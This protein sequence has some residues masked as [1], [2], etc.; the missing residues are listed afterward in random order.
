MD[1]VRP[2]RD[3]PLE[4]EVE[5]VARVFRRVRGD[6]LIEAIVTAAAAALLE[7]RTAT[8]PHR[9]ASPRSARP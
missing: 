2:R 6:P 1:D 5:A 4:P 3:T 8:R 9:A 7:R